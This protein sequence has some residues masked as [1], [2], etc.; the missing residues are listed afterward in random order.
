MI[1]LPRNLILAYVLTWAI[2]LV[3]LIF[4]ALKARRLRREEADLD[5]MQSSEIAR[6]ADAPAR[7]RGA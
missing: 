1:S 5:L 3:Y 4:L 6:K 7:P 2:H